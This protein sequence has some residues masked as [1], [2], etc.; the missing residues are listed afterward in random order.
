MIKRQMDGRGT[1]DQ[2]AQAHPH[3]GLTQMNTQD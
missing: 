1:V 3:R 2:D